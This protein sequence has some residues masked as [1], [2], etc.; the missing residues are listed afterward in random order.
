MEQGAGVEGSEVRRGAD[1][2]GDAA[3]Q[4]K[5]DVF[6]SKVVEQVRASETGRWRRFYIAPNHTVCHLVDG[7]K[8]GTHLCAG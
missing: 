7:A 5:T 4:V 6:L 3:A 2:A 8:K 1:T